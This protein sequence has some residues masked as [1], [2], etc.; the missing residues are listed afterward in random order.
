MHLVYA[1]AKSHHLRFFLLFSSPRWPSLFYFFFFMRSTRTPLH[2]GGQNLSSP[3][4]LCLLFD[5]W[6]CPCCW[7]WNFCAQKLGRKKKLRRL[8]SDRGVC[9]CVLFYT[10]TAVN[11]NTHTLISLMGRE[12]AERSHRLHR[13]VQVSS[14]RVSF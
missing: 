8:R 4:S 9:V 13:D 10:H 1:T 14:E 11:S 2:C 5:G 12:D 6:R 3:C 7:L